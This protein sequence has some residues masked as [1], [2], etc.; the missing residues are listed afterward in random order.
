VQS[1]LTEQQPTSQVKLV[2]EIKVNLGVKLGKGGYGVVFEGEWKNDKV[3]VKR[4]EKLPSA[5]G[6]EQEEEKALKKLEH[7]NVIKLLHV[8]SDATFR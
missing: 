6:D 2:L 5:K 1:P 7:P 8:E 3:A 4:I